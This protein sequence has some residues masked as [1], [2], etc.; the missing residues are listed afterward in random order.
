MVVFS[1]IYWILI[2]FYWSRG[3]GLY[4]LNLL[5][6][7]FWQMGRLLLHRPFYIFFCFSSKL[8]MNL[9]HQQKWHFLNLFRGLKWH[10]TQNVP[11]RPH[12]SFRIV[13]RFNYYLD[14]SIY[15]IINED[16]HVS[17]ISP[18]RHW[19]RRLKVCSDA[20]LQTFNTKP[21]FL[22]AFSLRSLQTGLTCSASYSDYLEIIP[23][24]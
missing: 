15:C 19:S 5:V 8:K 4:L 17:V 9:V 6:N 10:L 24:P 13:L 3:H 23:F 22:Q 2:R 12:Q 18:K 7:N 14:L 1:H 20:S 21:F 11:L 16:F